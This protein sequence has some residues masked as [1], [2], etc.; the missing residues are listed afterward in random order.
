MTGRMERWKANNAFPPSHRP[1]KSR[2]K[3]GEIPTFPSRDDWQF[4]RF[5]KKT[6]T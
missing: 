3:L 5:I 6:V 1:P 4:N 2:Q